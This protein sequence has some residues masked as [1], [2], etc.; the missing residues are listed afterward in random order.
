MD[1]AKNERRISMS[2]IMSVLCLF[3]IG[4][5]LGWCGELVF[6][7]VISKEQKW[8]NPGFLVGPYLPLYGFGLN[9]LFFLSRFEE[10]FNISNRVLSIVVLIVIMTVALTALEYIA[11]IIFIKGM[12]V[13]LWDYTGLFGNIDGI[14]CPIFSL[15]WGALGA[16]YYFAVHPYIERMLN[17]FSQNLSLIFIAGVFYGFFIIDLVYSLNLIT[18]IKRFAEEY[19]II[20][21]LEE[22]KINIRMNSERKKEKTHFFFALNSNRTL[23]SNL[24]QYNT[25]IKNL[26]FKAIKEGIK[27]E[28]QEL[29][30]K[31]KTEK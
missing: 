11:G 15:M 1:S 22:L 31:I 21:K 25:K 5:I 26:D 8:I 12:K 2:F 3:F 23:K 28:F 30:E 7:R 29:K 16:L 9:I 17:L 10:H 19:E 14:I 4:S 6:R 27:E 24:K 18:K 20:V 13:K